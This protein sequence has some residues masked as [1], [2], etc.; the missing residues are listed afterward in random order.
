MNMSNNGT[1]Q[2]PDVICPFCGCLCDDI[3]VAV[4]GNKI[5]KV[6]HACKIGTAKFLYASLRSHRFTS[7]LIKVD[8]EFKATTLENALEKAAEI[9][10]ESNKPLL[11]GWS[12]TS[13]EAQR[14]GVALAEATGGVIDATVTVCHGPSI[15]AIQD[16]GF[17]SITL[18]ECKNR[19][20]L[21]IYWGANPMA[22][23]PRHMSRYT[24]FPRGFFRERGLKDR[25]LIVVDVRKTDTAN[26]AGTFV[27]VRPNEDYELVSALRCIV[28]G[29]EITCK[30]VAGVPKEEIYVLA[31]K[32]MNCHF[33]VLFFG[34]GLTQSY[35]KIR[36]I[37]NAISLVRDLNR[38]TKFSLVP[39]RGHY[40]VTGFDEVLTWQTGYPFAVDFSRGYPRYNPGDTTTIDIL[41]RGEVDAA[42]IIA[43]DPG[44]HFPAKAVEHLAKIPLIAIDPHWTPTTEMA[45]VVIP[46]AIVGIETEGTAYRMDTVPLKLRKVIEPPEG[47][48]PDEEILKRLLEMVI[49]G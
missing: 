18:G 22:S 12:A 7:P 4:S 36:N 30:E 16:V 39:M 31:E 2:V 9:L 38:H 10:K 21:V 17:P 24:C 48:L 45:D 3:E 28:N 33:G 20:D 41:R 11:Y 5:E 34:Q 27:Q 26:I 47:I 1:R 6:K 37:D 46:S 23:H 13:C 42:L 32:M 49:N 35:G 44:A 43:S 14:V 29:G 8:G 19:S 15:L 40:N 25:E